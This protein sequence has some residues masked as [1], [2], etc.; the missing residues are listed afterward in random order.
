M[1]PTGMAK[2]SYTQWEFFFARHYQRRL[3]IYIANDDYQPDTSEPTSEDDPELQQAFLAHVV[4]EQGLDRSYF[5]NEDQLGRAVLKEDWPKKREHPIALPYLSLG[6]LFKGR[7]EFLQKLH[8]KLNRDDAAIVATVL[9]GL[10][11]IGKTRAAVEYAWAHHDQYTALLFV[12]AETPEALRRN[13]AALAGPLVLNLPEKSATEEEVRLKAVLDWLKEN[14]GWFL[15][16]D[17]IDT[18]EALADAESLLSKLSGGQVVITT[19]LANFAGHFDA[20]ELDVL[21][22]AAAFLLERTDRQRRKTAEDA[23]TARRLAVELGRLA[24]AL[25]QASAYIVKHVLPFSA[26]LQ[27]WEQYWEKVVGWADENITKYPRAVAVTW[28]TSVNQLPAAARRLLERLAWLAPE[29]MPNFLLD[30]PAPDIAVDD[31]DEAL[32]DLAA[33]SLAQRNPDKQD[34]S[35]HRLVQEA[36]RRSLDGAGTPA[37]LGR[38]AGVGRCRLRGRSAGHPDLDSARPAR[39][40]CTRDRRLRGYGRNQRTNRRIDEPTRALAGDQSSI[41]RGGA[42]LSPGAGD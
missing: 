28:R 6:G 17:N 12:I 30:A 24:L 18:P 14:P 5:S 25:E 8:K 35:V 27:N 37:Q 1:L 13:L 3:S 16:L 42:A 41:R 22:D 36:T 31:P 23:A 7:S 26:Y 9:Y 4:E 34:F 21:R 19:R 40:A 10:G 33:Y 15:I 2:A 29:P 39:A 20:L 38:G 11:G 32:A